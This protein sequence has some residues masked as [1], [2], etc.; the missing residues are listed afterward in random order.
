M[1]WK[2]LFTPA[3]SMDAEE[4]KAF[5]NKRS[6]G[7]FTLL[8]VRQPGEYETGHI[9]GSRLIPLPQLQDR[10]AEL[11]PAKPTIVYCAVGGRSRVAAQILSGKGF[12]EVYNLSGG[13]KAWS[14]A[15]V[16]GPQD[17]AFLFSAKTT[18]EVI[19]LAYHMES[20]LELYYK[21]LSGG[22]KG[23]A[24]SLLARLAAMEESHKQRVAEIYLRVTGSSNTDSLTAAGDGQKI[25]EGG[26]SMKD[27]LEGRAG[28][29]KTPEQILNAAMALE[30]QAL[31]L[32]AKVSMEASD[33]QVKEILRNLA[34]EE[35]AHLSVLGTMLEKRT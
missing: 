30:A 32:Y 34:D 19:K 14:G 16:E 1:G 29:L 26:L 7:S 28:V 12:R 27:F 13:I 18:E 10:L 15:K 20:G 11:D 3:P 25:M 22:L 35:K 33:P 24:S 21:T 9:P 31:D 2:E 6:Q 23:E 4:A 17:V 5:M 8:D